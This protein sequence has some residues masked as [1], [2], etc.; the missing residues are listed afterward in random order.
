[1]KTIYDKECD[2]LT[3]DL[4]KGTYWKSI[5]LGPGVILDISKEG[6]LLGLEILFASKVFSKN[7][8]KV[9]QH[10]NIVHAEA[11]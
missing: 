9:L 2:A 6:D 1:M 7:L 10:A 11:H 5:E 8:A 4:K 3:I